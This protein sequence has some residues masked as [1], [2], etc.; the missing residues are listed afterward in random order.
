M[1][2]Y[3][4]GTAIDTE[5]LLQ[6][7]V[8]MTSVNRKN[9]DVQISCPRDWNGLD[10]QCR[11]WIKERFQRGRLN[12]QLKVESTQS[13]PEGFEWNS[14]SMDQSLEQLRSYAESRNIDFQVNSSLLLNLAKTLKENTSLPD[15][16]TL[17]D[18]IESAFGQAL[19]EFN[20]MRSSEGN[21]LGR[22]FTQ[23]I[24]TLDSL[25]K[26]IAEYAKNAVPKYRTALIARL[27]QLQLD[28]N[29]DDERVL[30]EIALFADRCDVS[31]ELTRLNSHLEQF[32]E[33]IL[34]KGPIGRKMDFLCQEINREFNTIGSKVTAI[35]ST[36]AV[37]EAKNEL[38]RIREQVQ[39]IE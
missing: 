18:T 38:E 32:R 39:N 5:N 12:I 3:G 9:M 28:L 26:Q 2:G 11:L 8:E 25:R 27:K 24:Q 23:R 13:V 35:E 36:R 22:D 7:E 21:A 33:F 15:W 19:T 6:I 4:R 1:T 30:K 29:I 34:S 37:I 17:Q 16:S 10:Q 20:T 14:E 31:E